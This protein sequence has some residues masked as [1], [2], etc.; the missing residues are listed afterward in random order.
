M[1][2]HLFIINPVAGKKDRSGIIKKAI[3]RMLM[4]EPCETVV[5]TCVGDA[6]EIVKDRLE[7]LPEDSF[8]RI[9]SC[10][11]DGTLSEV[12]EGVY[13]TKNRN[14]AIG[15]VPIGSGNDF[16]KYF[17]EIPAEKFRSLPDMVKGNI[18]S[19][20]I[21]SV[22]DSEGNNERISV[23]IVSAGYDAAVA[24]GMEKYKKIPLV[25]GKAAYNLSVAECLISKMKNK[26]TL[27]ADGEEIIDK[28]NDYLFAICANGS[29]YGG[30]FKASPL[31]NIKDGMMN[32]IR[33][34]TVSRL[35]FAALV[36]AFRKGEHLIK[37]KKYCTHALCRELKIIS[38]RIIDINIDGNIIPMKN[39]TISI[40]PNEIKLI[41]PN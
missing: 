8:L 28:D 16:V 15:V 32:F 11:G 1:Q 31:S 27:V 17:S 40:I 26:F 4:I 39:P 30:G 21:I 19:C 24:K 36:G 35:T 9:Y 3:E 34:K 38:D 14:C 41:L 5:T 22:K 37:L 13:K 12:V 18:D 2:K 10:G 23:N 6:T 33:I 7:K 25:S 29:Y 20:D